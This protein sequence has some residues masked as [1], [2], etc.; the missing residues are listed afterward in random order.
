[1]M[2]RAPTLLAWLVLTLCVAVIAIAHAL[3]LLGAGKSNGSWEV[4]ASFLT[5]PA[6]GALIIS[7]RPKNTVGWIFCAIGMGAATTSFSAGYVS[8]AVAK[9]TDAQ[10][11]TGLIDALGNAVWPVNMGLG[12]LLLFLFPDGKL[13][14]RR[15]RPAFWVDVGCIGA[16]IVAGL[17]HV[18]PLE[19]HGRVVNPIG[20]G[21][22]RPLLS[23]LQNIA[24]TVFVFATLAAI[25]SVV[26]RY[27]HATGVQRQQI[28]WFAYGGVMIALIVAVTMILADTLTPRGQ[29]PSTTAFSNIGFA[30]GFTMLPLGAG[31]GVL[32]YR[33]YD[34]DILINRTLVYGSLT[35]VL[36][37]VYF[38]LVFVA[39][40]LAQAMRGQ[41]KPQ[42]LIIVAST[43]L[44]ATL[45]NPLRHRIQTAIDRR[46]YRRKYDA[47]RTL[48]AFAASLRNQV[49]LAELSAHLLGVVRE[50]MQPAH[51]SLWLRPDERKR[52][53]T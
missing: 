47:S 42:P 4:T 7:R 28:K 37:A 22:A 17:L 3:A 26:V 50:T 1:M 51:V 23:A 29:D 49:E 20:A 2:R 35:A 27:R 45:F 5:F 30:I 48:E 14:S 32:R 31:I 52:S 13:P 36:A 19:T 24:Q 46:F 40:T 44:I 43:L 11:A 6:V 16:M 53:S 9:H 8:Y 34:I 33:L 10:L 25:V 18:G 21:G 38:G 12:S 39:Q 41:T 15:W